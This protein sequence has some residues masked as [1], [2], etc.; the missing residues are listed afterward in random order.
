M[1]TAVQAELTSLNRQVTHWHQAAIHLSAIDQLASENAWQGIEYNMG[2][3][4]RKSLLES[5]SKVL[6]YAE[7]L[8]LELKNAEDDGTCRAIK[9]KVVLLRE[10]YL[11]AEETIHFYTV[12][13]N[14]RT[15]SNISALLRACDILCTKSMD[16]V[17]LPLD[18]KVPFVLT[19]I[20]KGVGASILKAGLR[21]WDGNISPVAA[22]KVTLHN[23]FR[24][25]AI[26][27]E[28]GHQVAHILNWNEELARELQLK[29]SEHS[30]AV[31]TAFSSWA[32]EI[33]A[34]A[35]AFVNTGFAAVAALNDVVSG[36]IQSVFAFHPLDP[37]PISYVRILLGIEMCRQ[38]YGPGPWDTLEMSFKEDYNIN[39][40]NFPSV[41]LIKMCVDAIPDAVQIILKSPY[42]AFG[43]KSLAQ[44]IPPDNVSPKA[45]DKLEYIAGPALYTSHAWI[46]KECIKLLALIGYKIGVGENELAPLYK[47]Q[48]EWMV[49]LG[50]SIGVN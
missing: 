30:P 46:W 12:A 50:F 21:L 33:A 4:L 31:G 3:L 24:P 49:R 17:L 29:L 36:R 39:E 45:L 5:V 1:I 26:I 15:T 8:K 16:A 19:Y 18:K 28:S 10:H 34:D 25:T 43:G 14:S 47:L 38:F 11:K 44:A 48:E 40:V 41:G 6:T 42:L 13:I 9:N 37:H 23:L 35:F 7:N 32:S 20:D 22:I 2:Q 27:H